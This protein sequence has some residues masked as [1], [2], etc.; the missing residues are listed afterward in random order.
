MVEILFWYPVSPDT[1]TALTDLCFALCVFQK[2]LSPS[3]NGSNIAIANDRASPSQSPKDEL[4]ASN[5]TPSQTEAGAAST[6]EDFT[7][8]I[9]DASA[10]PDSNTKAELAAATNHIAALTKRI[11]GVL[12]A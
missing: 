8:D 11:N 6:N 1:P 2:R 4:T 12:H 7:V 3:N 9:P 10:D 5:A